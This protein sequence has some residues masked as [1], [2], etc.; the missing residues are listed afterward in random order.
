MAK[1]KKDAGNELDTL[2]PGKEVALGDDQAVVVRPLSLESLPK[3]A[4][5]F[6][7][8]MRLAETGTLP[9][10]LAVAGMEEL[11]QILPFCI[12]RPANEIPSTVV[13]EIIEIVIDQNLTD[14]VVGKWQAL[15]QRAVM[16][17]EGEVGD[18]S[19]S[20]GKE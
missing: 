2:F 16:L 8:I 11:L 6:G 20:P 7:K 1:A 18:Q 5:A 10:E 14:D 3:V 17:Q 4:K 9:S 19:K 15:I 12:D 13:P